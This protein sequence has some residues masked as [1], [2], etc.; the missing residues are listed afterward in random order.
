MLEL[1]N[2]NNK[3]FAQIV[4]EAKKHIR[5]IDP[6]WTDH[7]PHDPGITILEM[8]AFLK[9]AQHQMMDDIGPVNKLKYLELL[10]TSLEEAKCAVTEVVFSAQGVE[11]IY[12][13]KGTK[14]KA[15]S[16]IFE[17]E[18]RAVVSS[19]ILSKVLLQDEKAALLLSMTSPE[20]KHR[21]W[22]AFG[23]MPREGNQFYL[24]FEQ[25][26][27]SEEK[28]RL[29]INVYSEYPIKRN[30]VKDED[31][32][33]PLVRLKWEYYG[34]ESGVLGWHSV[35]LIEDGTY[36]LL[37]SGFL[38]FRIG[39][40]QRIA[41]SLAQLGLDRF[42]IRCTLVSGEYDLPPLIKSVLINCFPVTQRQTLCESLVFNHDA[43]VVENKLLIDSH[44]AY[45]GQIRVFIKESEYWKELD[46]EDFQLEKD[47]EKKLCSLKLFK[48]LE[49]GDGELA[50]KVLAFD[51]SFNQQM[52]MG[53]GTDFIN[54]SYDFELNNLLSQE[55]ALMIGV[56]AEKDKLHWYDWHQIKSLSKAG[57]EERCYQLNSTAGQIFFGNNRR[58]LVPPKGK[59]NLLMTGCVTTKAANGNILSSRIQQFVEDISNYGS[60]EMQQLLPATG[61]QDGESIDQAEGRMRQVLKSK[62]RAINM[63]DYQEI[64][65]KT[66]GLMI[67]NVKVLPLYKPGM[68]GYPQSKADNCVTLVVESYNRDGQSKL[69]ATYKKN[70]L[71]YLEMYRLITTKLYVIEPTYVGLEIYGEIVIKVNFGNAERII[72]EALQKHIYSIQ[73]GQQWEVHL[74]YGDIYGAIDLLDCVSHIKYLAMEP[75]DHRVT[76]TNKGDIVIPAHSRFYLKK[77]DLT[78]INS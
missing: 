66:P 77:A 9:K 75:V 21:D 33:Q 10:N 13:P 46:R 72:Q 64:V 5:N 26:L 54:Q 67:K 71:D 30:P 19:N 37:F 73:Q 1:P 27:P 28:I 15:N 44:L 39:G 62:S 4:E 18:E 50:I 24:G 42:P 68:V 6:N 74:S 12:L 14:L 57:R 59:D 53:S 22:H 43:L 20:E 70:I 2:L 56:A 29:K 41:P 32:F 35:E 63:E 55:F 40:I 48:Q 16:I 25:P 34:E 47:A 49:L 78:L 23:S 65:H 36:D 61:G 45:F 76:K 60:L 7:S 58:G 31:S 11:Q 69:S 3:S 8:L 51:Q 52:V 17:L 38:S